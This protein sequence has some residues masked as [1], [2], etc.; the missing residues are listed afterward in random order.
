[1]NNKNLDS[2]KK[3]VPIKKTAESKELNSKN[4]KINKIKIKAITVLSQ[5]KKETTKMKEL[6]T[7]DKKKNAAPQ[8]RRA[9]KE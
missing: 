2:K 6:N 7:K 8:P 1:M 9:E 5:P 3:N 4:K